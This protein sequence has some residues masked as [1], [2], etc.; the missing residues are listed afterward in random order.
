MEYIVP[1]MQEQGRY[2]RAVTCLTN[3]LPSV[4]RTRYVTRQGGK[5]VHL[6]CPL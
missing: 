1:L 4:W 6:N 2:K 5:A 3:G